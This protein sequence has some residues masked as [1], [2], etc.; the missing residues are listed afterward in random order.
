[1]KNRILAASTIL[2]SAVAA[3]AQ[4]ISQNQQGVQAVEQQQRLLQYESGRQ[5]PELYSGESEDIGPQR[6]LKLTPRH[7]YF[8][9]LVDSQYFFTSNVQLSE[10]GDSSTIFVNTVEPIFTTPDYK[11][12]NKDFRTQ[13]G[14]RAQ[15]YNFG[16]DGSN[17]GFGK[18][19]FHAQVAYAYES[20]VPAEN[21][22]VSLGV[23]ATRLLT[24][25]D[26]DE[27]YKEV[28]PSW[29]VSRQFK[30]DQTR[31]FD[32]G[33][34]GY[35][36]FS[37]THNALGVSI[38]GLSL[39][40][41]DVNNRFEQL[42]TLAYSQAITAKLI[43][44][45]FYQFQYNYYTEAPRNDFLNTIGAFVTY[46]FCP[47]ASVRTFLNWQDRISDRPAAAPEYD[48][49]DVGIGATLDIKF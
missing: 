44:T 40:A 4:P 33:Y 34:Q 2:A 15:W 49:F 24:Q 23:E 3:V 46:N 35:Y 12:W 18:F 42:L 30:L 28:A 36:R 37:E 17:N 32:V 22:R 25:P 7:R 27:F 38:P 1:M 19:D 14:V 13:V 20:F 5:A 9:A 39:G 10:N 45:P 26:Y 21:W 16:L 8:E 29:A 11:L 31:V 43:V 41:D 6:L 47:H 48:K